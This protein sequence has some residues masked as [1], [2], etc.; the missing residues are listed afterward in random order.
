[1]AIEENPIFPLTRIG[2][3]DVFYTPTTLPETFTAVVDLPPVPEGY[4]NDGLRQ[5][6]WTL[7][8]SWDNDDI[9]RLCYQMGSAADCLDQAHLGHFG[10]SL[11]NIQRTDPTA[12]RV[13]MTV[14]VTKGN[15]ESLAWLIFESSLE[16]DA[17]EPPAA[18]ETDT[19][20]DEE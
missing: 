19:C 2:I 4:H 16:P 3:N 14:T 8:G 15:D 6:V 13:T 9:L 5:R 18:V 10:W 12:N 1:V 20:Y 7:L 17:P 11:L